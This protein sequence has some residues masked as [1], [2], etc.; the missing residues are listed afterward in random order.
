VFS[1]G[2][3]RSG[4]ESI[5]HHGW[6]R[7][8]T[9]FAILALRTKGFSLD[10]AKAVIAALGTVANDIIILIATVGPIYATIRGVSS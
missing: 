8:G 1:P 6:D 3:V 7:A 2:G 9:A 10:Q 5:R 4:Q